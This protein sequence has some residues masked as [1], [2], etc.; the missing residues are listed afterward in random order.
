ML[1]STTHA[2]CGEGSGWAAPQG[3]VLCGFVRWQATKLP[4]GMSTVQE[5]MYRNALR[6][7]LVLGKHAQVRRVREPVCT[8]VRHGDPLHCRTVRYELVEL[9]LEVHELHGLAAVQ[10][11][12]LVGRQRETQC[13]Q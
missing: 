7:C 6:H 4:T 2:A 3:G 11:E 9:D 10:V 13:H 1:T 12:R 8:L 5:L